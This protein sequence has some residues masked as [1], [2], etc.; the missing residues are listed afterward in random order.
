MTKG[1]KALRDKVIVTNIESG[2]RLTTKG[3]IIPDDDGKER[4][5]RP[6]WCEVYAVGEE[7]TD[8]KPGEWILVSHGRWTRGMDIQ[9]PDGK[10][11]KDGALTGFTISPE[12]YSSYLKNFRDHE[13]I[14]WKNGQWKDGKFIGEKLPK[15]ERYSGRFVS[16]EQTFG[17][18]IVN[19][20]DTLKLKWY[21]QIDTW[22]GYSKYLG[23]KNSK[24][25]KRPGF[26][27]DYHEFNPIATDNQIDA[28]PDDLD[29][30]KEE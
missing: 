28:E 10:T 11:V 23:S 5:I 27:F 8:I 21:H 12:E 13:N 22:E 4:G 17:S 16:L 3:I 24:R 15:E 18:A 30:Q 19:E 6:R 26:G 29:E 9:T 7:I 20:E 25:V 2:A 1:I 14:L